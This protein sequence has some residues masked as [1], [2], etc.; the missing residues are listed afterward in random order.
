MRY[1]FFTKGLFFI[2]FNMVIFESCSKIL[3]DDNLTL[4]RSNYT[5][6]ELNINGVYYYYMYSENNIDYY[7]TYILYRNGI[8]RYGGTINNLND[9]NN[10]ILDGTKKD[11]WGIYKINNT[12]IMIETWQPAN[13]MSGYSVYMQEGIILNDKSFKLIYIY[14]SNSSDKRIIDKIYTLKEI[15]P[16][17]D[18]TNNYIK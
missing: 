11:H 10:E 3:V 17:P 12:Q 5:G 18:S 7:D 13:T 4:K 16:K 14:K 9:I 8:V 1:L 2:F 6:I 15:N